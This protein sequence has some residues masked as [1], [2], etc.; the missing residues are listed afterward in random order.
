MEESGNRKI[1]WIFT[2]SFY[3]CYLETVGELWP[4]SESN[5]ELVAASMYRNCRT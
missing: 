1:K 3:S 4:K 2:Q 5:K